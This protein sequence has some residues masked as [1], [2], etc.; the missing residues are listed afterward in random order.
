MA[1]S[2]DETGCGAFNA[3]V[4]F[5]AAQAGTVFKWGVLADIT[6]AP[7]TW[8]L[9]TEVPNENSNQR[10]RSFALAADATEQH[11]WLAVG[12][13]FGARKH[14]PPGAA[15]PGVRFVVWASSH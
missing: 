7:N 4:S 9:V 10:Y 11:Y 15:V 2:Q 8:V 6:G 13:R 3:S 1:A 14:L 12:R 5:D